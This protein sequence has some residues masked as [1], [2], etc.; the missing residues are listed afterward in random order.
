MR[1][2]ALSQKLTSLTGKIWNICNFETD[3]QSIEDILHTL[4]DNRGISDIEN[5]INLPAYDGNFDASSLID[6]E[7]AAERILKAINFNE[8]IVIM[9]DYDVDGISSTSIFLN[10]LNHLKIPVNFV[11][12]NRISGYGL[13]IENIEKYKDHLI[14]A[15]DCGSSALEELTYGQKHNIDIVVI[16]HH[17]METIPYACALV[18]PHRPDESDLYKNLCATGLVFLC[19]IKLNQL[20]KQSGFFKKNNIPEINILNFLD[21]VALATV[22][23]VVPLIG[24][25]RI[26]VKDGL[27]L[28]KKRLNIGI[29]ALAALNKSR[30]ISSET[31]AYF[32]GPRLNAAGRIDSADI[33]VKLLTTK[34]PVE[35]K[36]IA[37]HL[38]EL[39]QERQKLES[40][41]ISEAIEMVDPQLNF[42]CV[43]HE[44]WHLG[45][46]G[47]V[48]GRL[49]EKF[50]RPS[51]V[52]TI[53]SETG[54]GKASCR[55]T[56][57]VNI[58]SIIK[59][60]IA[61]GLIISGGGHA[62]AAGFSIHSKNLENFKKFLETEITSV[63][64]PHELYADCCLALNEINLKFFEN[65]S[66]FEPF[67]MANR[68]PRFVLKNLK[69]SF[70]KIVGEKHISLILK[71]SNGH[72]IKSISFKSVDSPL[73]DLLMTWDKTFYA[74]GSLCISEWNG[75]RYINFQLDDIAEV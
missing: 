63:P 39:N 62:L 44:N 12:P 45:V 64:H 68:A 25:N 42:I 3:H 75:N 50:N 13:S 22:C 58:S 9:G 57:D 19:C 27:N 11:I 49:R 53:D 1:E 48:A 16:D 8:K 2:N 30:D 18:N 51:I 46:I 74:L 26:F 20:L 15:V 72:S 17:T 4:A 34:N 10:F 59:K 66:K 31:I 21:L 29:D 14:I 23:D 61:K 55:S 24:L 38:D 43:A 65:I 5:F 69:T 71:D 28:I 52:I 60:A 73:G 47:I 35:A 6:M 36:Q 70:R 56:D 40:E 7:K 32:F 37:H 54:I 67:G 33:S 41:M